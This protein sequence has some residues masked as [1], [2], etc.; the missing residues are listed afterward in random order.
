[1]AAASGGFEPVLPIDRGIFNWYID[2]H[3]GLI[4]KMIHGTDTRIKYYGGFSL[5]IALGGWDAETTGS[6]TRR[7]K[8][9]Q[10][11]FVSAYMKGFRV[12]GEHASDIDA[13]L[14]GVEQEKEQA[15]LKE[16]LIHGRNSDT[17]DNFPSDDAAL[18]SATWSAT[19]KVERGPPYKLFGD[20]ACI[21]RGPS[22]LAGSPIQYII[23]HILNYKVGSV[24]RY[25]L[26]LTALYKEGASWKSQVL[27]ELTP[28]SEHPGK[29]TL[30]FT[31]T[32]LQT[33]RKEFE[34]L[35]TYLGNQR[36]TPERNARLEKTESRLKAIRAAFFSTAREF[37]PG[38]AAGQGGGR[39]RR[40][41]RRYRRRSVKK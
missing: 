9:K 5:N 20:N 21:L 38:S 41:T 36:H 6:Q 12:V 15:F 14:L 25:Q 27:S 2:H 37:I 10:P 32:P 19:Y 35:K 23:G 39:R 11:P 33:L 40:Q 24:I 26:V 18:V 31:N 13:K 22:E 8:S 7:S 3:Q 17:P 28:H 34:S 29:D 30:L 4:R 1:M 16:M